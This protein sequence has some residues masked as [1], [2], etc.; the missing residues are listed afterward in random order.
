MQIQ[1]QSPKQSLDRAYLKT[2]VE[3]AQI[4]LFKA[5]LSQFLNKAKQA[6]ERQESEEHLKNLVKD[7][8]K[9][10]YYKDRYEINTGGRADLVIHHGP[11]AGNTAAVLMEVKRPGNKA[12]LKEIQA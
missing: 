1:I 2:K 9:D 6:I 10:T 4:E 3:R 8:L 11:T 5:N 12:A 7:F